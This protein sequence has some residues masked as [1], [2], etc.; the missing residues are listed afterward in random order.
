MKLE[1]HGIVFCRSNYDQN[2]SE[3][4]KLTDLNLHFSNLHFFFFFFSFNC[5]FCAY[6]FPPLQLALLFCGSFFFYLLPH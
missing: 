2:S 6:H 1:L 3:M 4:L 5:L